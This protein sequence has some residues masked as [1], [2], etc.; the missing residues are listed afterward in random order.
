PDALVLA[1]TAAYERE[2]V[3]AA[4]A[5]WERL[6]KRLPPESEDAQ[7]LAESIKKARA[8]AQKQIRKKPPAAKP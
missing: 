5:H 7:S 6:L 2:D 4:A 3:A 8:A 1:G